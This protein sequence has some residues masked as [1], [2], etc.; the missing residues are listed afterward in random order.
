MMDINTNKTLNKI[1]FIKYL[2]KHL[3]ENM[4]NNTYRFPCQTLPSTSEIYKSLF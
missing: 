3:E 1:P 4:F 2:K